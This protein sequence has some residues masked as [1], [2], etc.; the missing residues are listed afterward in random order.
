MSRTGA[1]SIPIRLVC[2]SSVATPIRTS[3]RK[4]FDFCGS[5][6]LHSLGTKD[7]RVGCGRLARA[8][9][10]TDEACCCIIR[11]EPTMRARLVT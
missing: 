11:V 6:F 4:G 3:L 1:K 5:R 8:M 10:Q 9:P 2:Q 7:S